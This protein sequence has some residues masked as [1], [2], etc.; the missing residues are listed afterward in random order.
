MPSPPVTVTDWLRQ[1]EALREGACGLIDVAYERLVGVSIRP[2]ARRPSRIEALLWGRF[3]HRW[4]QGNRCWLY[5]RQPRRFPR[6]LVLDYLIS[7]RGT[8]LATVRGSLVLLE[9]IARLKGTDA[10]LCDVATARIS[11]RLLAREGWA[12]HAPSRW[13]RNYIKRFYG[14]YPGDDELLSRL[15]ASDQGTRPAVQLAL[16]R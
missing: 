3:A 5:Y 13:H 14:E 9:E 7:T 4:R 1:A 10:L 15:L 2:F 16:C 6:Y 8:K 12:P 11:H